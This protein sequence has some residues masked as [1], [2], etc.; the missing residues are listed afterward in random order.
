MRHPIPAS[1]EEELTIEQ[2]TVIVARNLD[3]AVTCAEVARQVIEEGGDRDSLLPG[4]GLQAV[5]EEIRRALHFTQ[6][7]Q[8]YL[9]LA[10]ERVGTGGEAAG[11]SEA[12]Q[13]PAPGV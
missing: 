4:A 8:R 9:D 1:P 12:V 11:S 2:L 13:A 3:F 5:E 10:K 7:A 6:L